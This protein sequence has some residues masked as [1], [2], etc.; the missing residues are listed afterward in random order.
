MSYLNSGFGRKWFSP[1]SQYN[2]E[3][4]IVTTSCNLGVGRLE[5]RLRVHNLG[6]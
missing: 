4:L 1:Y 6:N 2:R 3:A 5:H